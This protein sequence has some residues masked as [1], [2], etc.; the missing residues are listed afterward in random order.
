M[1]AKKRAKAESAATGEM[2]KW[3]LRRCSLGRAMNH[4]GE[5]D[6]GALRGS[7]RLNGE[8]ESSWLPRGERL[9]PDKRY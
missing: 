6:M 5:A 9:F 3:L 8:R 2:G 4:R 7:P 1:V